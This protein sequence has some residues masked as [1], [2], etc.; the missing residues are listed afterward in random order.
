MGLRSFILVSG[1]TMEALAARRSIVWSELRYVRVATLGALFVSYNNGKLTKPHYIARA[2]N[3]VCQRLR[4]ED[5]ED[6]DFVLDDDALPE[7]FLVSD[8]E[9]R[10]KRHLVFAVEAQLELQAK[11]KTWYIDDTFKLVRRPFTQLLTINAFVRSGES[12]KQVSLVYVLMS[13]RK[14]KDYMKASF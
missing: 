10:N 3:K 8:I 4:P 9:I 2:A 1:N 11:A 14:K 6:L 12:F 13:S 5:R 7:N